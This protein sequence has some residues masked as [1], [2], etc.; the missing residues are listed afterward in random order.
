MCGC[1]L[2]NSLTGA[3]LLGTQEHGGVVLSK[4]NLNAIELVESSSLRVGER[5]V[6]VDFVYDSTRDG[7]RRNIADYMA[8]STIPA[9]ARAA[10]TESRGDQTPPKRRGR[11]LFTAQDQVRM[12]QFLEVRASR[13]QV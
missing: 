7:V 5:W 1:R 8:Q 9:S 12:N 11:M 10:E 3:V 2:N 4:T 6:S 13:Q